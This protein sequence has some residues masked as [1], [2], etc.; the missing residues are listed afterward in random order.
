MFSK[1]LV[2]VDGSEYSRQAVPAAIEVA[3]K[4]EVGIFVLHV[5]EHDL[6]RAAAYPVE[7]EDQA[8]QIVAD[9][10]EVI[11]A[12]GV[13]AEGE[14][15]VAFMGQVADEIAETAAIQGAN[16]IVM[17]SRGLS[18][19]AGLFLGSVTHKVIRLAKAAVLIDRTAPVVETASAEAAPAVASDYAFA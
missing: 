6:G 5:H 7:S 9:A 2:A 14:V 19:V 10:V 3:K 4:F 16:L 15:R 12:A 1:I 11:R 18:D 13:S 17:G 8:V